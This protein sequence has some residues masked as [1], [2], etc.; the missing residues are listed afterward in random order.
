LLVSD[1]AK[2]LE[3][4]K[5]LADEYSRKI[6]L[7]I[8]TRSLPIESISHEQNI[9]IS[10]CYRRIRELESCGMVRADRT[11]VEGDGK[12]YVCYKSTFTGASIRL[13]SGEVKVDLIS[14][15]SHEDR[16]YDNWKAMSGKS[17]QAGVESSNVRMSHNTL[18][19]NT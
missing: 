17:G 9:P 8:I 3:V 13:E 16:L 14:N 4:V 10:T 11:I 1:Q 6:V 5:T 7:S 12:K 15:R 18:L 2:A 19:L